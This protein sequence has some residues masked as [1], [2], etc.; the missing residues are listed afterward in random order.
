VH[1]IPPSISSIR[2]RR[3]AGGYATIAALTAL[4]M[5]AA[6]MADGGAAGAATHQVRQARVPA[7]VTLRVADQLET[8]QDLLAD[9]GEGSGFPYKVQYSEFVGGPPMLQAFQAGS[10]DVGFVADTPIIFAQAAGQNLSAVAAWGPEHGSDALVTAPGVKLSG[11]KS[12]K[13]RKVAYQVGTVEEA[14]V[15]EGLHSVGLTLNDITTVNLPTT[16]ITPALE[17][18]SVDAGI[19]VQPLTAAYL[20]ANKTARQVLVGN[21][22][23]A[24]VSMLIADKTSLTNTG[25]RAALADYITRVDKAIQWANAHQAQYAQDLYVDKYKVPLAE[26]EKLLAPQQVLANL[27]YGAGEIPTKVNVKSEFSGIFNNVV[28]SVK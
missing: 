19:L 22:V 13:G 15:L 20:D 23:T 16:S 27:Y 25:T 10:I 8:V 5:A 2:R 18:G 17:N 4:T 12:L 3:R 1:L 24:R 6:G 21:D 11:W 28:S 9:A 14:V 7:G 26:G